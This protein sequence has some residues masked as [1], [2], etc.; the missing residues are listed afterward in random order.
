MPKIASHSPYTNSGGTGAAAGELG[1]GRYRTERTARRGFVDL[2]KREPLPG[3]ILH[4]VPTW[5]K[6]VGQR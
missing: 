4:K 5:N 2:S 6:Q 3:A 1:H